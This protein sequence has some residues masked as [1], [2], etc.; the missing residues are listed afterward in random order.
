MT[1]LRVLLSFTEFLGTPFS[2]HGVPERK[3]FLVF[4]RG[5]VVPWSSLEFI[6]A[7]KSFLDFLR[8]PL[9][10]SDGHGNMYHYYQ[11]HLRKTFTLLCTTNK[12]KRL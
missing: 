4:F 7:V 3:F 2:F 12:A 6:G 8:V 10:S 11:H 9:S 1:I 5:L